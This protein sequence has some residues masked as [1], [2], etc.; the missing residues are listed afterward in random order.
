MINH[1]A[2]CTHA[3][4]P[5]ARKACRKVAKVAA[6]KVAT[7]RLATVGNGKAIHM[8][9]SHGEYTRCGKDQNINPGAYGPIT[10]ITCKSCINKYGHAHG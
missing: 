9:E 7:V 5:A 10:A 6:P 8:L 1:K 2:N 3:Q 4:T